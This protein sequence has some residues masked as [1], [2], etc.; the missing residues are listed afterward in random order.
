MIKCADAFGVTS[1]Y[2]PDCI[3]LRNYQSY[4]DVPSEPYEGQTLN[5]TLDAM[6]WYSSKT[7]MLETKQPD[8]QFPAYNPSDMFIRVV[9]YNAEDNK[10]SE[11]Q[12]TYVHREATLGD[13]KVKLSVKS[14]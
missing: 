2:P 5:R 7:V 14:F 10:F 11:S 9:R 8:E 12:P 6:N 4:N 3:R 1:K 13:L